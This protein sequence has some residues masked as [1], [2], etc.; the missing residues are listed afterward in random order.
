ML[1]SSHILGQDESLL[2]ECQQTFKL[3]PD[4]CM[5]FKKMQKAAQRDGIDLQILSSYRNFDRQLL[6]W[7]N[8]WS[9]IKPILDINERVLDI[10]TLSTV[11]KMHAILT[12]SAL[13]GASRHHWGT[14]LDVYDKRAVE[15][16]KG[17]FQLVGSEYETES[18][19]CHKLNR[20]LAEHA[21]RYGFNRPY[22]EYQGGVAAEPWHISYQPLA[23]QIIEQLSLNAL[24]D[25]LKYSSI[26]QIDCILD[27]LEVIF[28]QY[29]LNKGKA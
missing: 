17:D 26:S 4:V 21:Q 22:A 25:A 15:S 28:H 12:W 3:L 23:D 27:H 29:V 18:G 8:K 14:D 6:I 11:E 13:P 9:G 7:K 20:W 19:P 24:A 16:H 2:V 5:A 10:N 1:T